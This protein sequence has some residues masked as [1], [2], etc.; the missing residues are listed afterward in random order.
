MLKRPRG[1]FD[2]IIKRRPE[3]RLVPGGSGQPWPRPALAQP[4][5]TPSSRAHGQTRE[6][7]SQVRTQT[8]DQT[9]GKEAGEL[10]DQTE[11]EFNDSLSALLR[12][13][14][15][16]SCRLVAGRPGKERVHVLPH[17]VPT[18]FSKRCTRSHSSSCQCRSGSVQFLGSC[19]RRMCWSHFKTSLAQSVLHRPHRSARRPQVTDRRRAWEENVSSCNGLTGRMQL[20]K[21]R[22]KLSSFLAY[23]SCQGHLLQRKPA[24][25]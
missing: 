5:A 25:D 13:A 3:C 19:A 2:K 4:G 12:A 23:T 11:N 24:I 16:P 7:T 15:A 8:A 22:C 18:L 6:N 10:P 14:R 1:H 20:I 21:C 9:N 17:P